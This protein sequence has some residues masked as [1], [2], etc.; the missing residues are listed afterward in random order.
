MDGLNYAL[1]WL[2]WRWMLQESG[3]LSGKPHLC[4]GGRGRVGTGWWPWGHLW[5]WLSHLWLHHSD[6]SPKVESDL[7]CSLS[8][9]VCQFVVVVLMSTLTVSE[10]DE[11]PG[12]P[13]LHST[14][15]LPKHMHTSGVKKCTVWVPLLKQWTCWE[16]RE[17]AHLGQAGTRL[18]GKWLRRQVL[19]VLGSPPRLPIAFHEPHIGCQG[20]LPQ[21]NVC[22][23][24]KINQKIGKG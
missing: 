17:W 21:G 13:G 2:W 3:G 6:H 12:F 23:N 20:I 19:D 5:L 1:V 9:W 22:W 18:P 8:F 24:R 10:S 4:R 7:W 14:P 16:D 15:S 11:G